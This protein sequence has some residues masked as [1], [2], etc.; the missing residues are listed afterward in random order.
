MAKNKFI[1]FNQV[2]LLV[3]LLAFGVLLSTHKA[4]AAG[5]VCVTEPDSSGYTVSGP[6]PSWGWNGSHCFDGHT[7]GSY[8]V[9]GSYDFGGNQ[10]L[11]D[12]GTITFSVAGG[13]G[14][15]GGTATI[16]V[17][18]NSPTLAY[19]I[20]RSDGYVAGWNGS[21]CFA[22]H[23]VG[24]TYWITGGETGYYFSS[25]PGSQ[26]MGSGGITFNITYTAITVNIS[27][28]SNV[29]TTWTLSG[30]SGPYG[31]SG[32][33][34]GYNGVPCGQYSVSAPAIS[35]YTVQVSPGPTNFGC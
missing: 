16:C 10:T 24:L 4:L 2:G 12:G 9:S 3:F 33:S 25:S 35:G 34:Q 14:G 29:S 5:T 6:D 17:N 18:S 1:K 26:V 21:N 23:P 7:A 32:T 8:S 28:T 20:N 13:G 11:S 27:V 19:Y 31:G 30:P 22:G 15:G